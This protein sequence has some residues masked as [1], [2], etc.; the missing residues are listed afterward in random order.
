MITIYLDRGRVEGVLTVEAPNSGP[1]PTSFSLSI[2]CLARYRSLNPPYVRLIV[3]GQH[4]NP[5]WISRGLVFKRTVATIA[6]TRNCRGQFPLK[7]LCGL[8]TIKFVPFQICPTL[9]IGM[10]L[11]GCLAGCLAGH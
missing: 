11:S 9:D 2:V 1:R 8:E 5:F 6:K 10:Q 7:H 4:K 3:G